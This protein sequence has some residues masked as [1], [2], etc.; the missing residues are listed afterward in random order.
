MREAI[1]RGALVRGN[2]LGNEIE[3]AKQFG[4]SRPT[5]RRAIQELVNQGL[6]VRK[7]GVGTQ[8]V[9]DE[10]TR[11]LQL[12]GLFDD[13]ARD[14]KGPETTVLAH[15]VGIPP[16]GVAA[17]LHIGSNEP[18]LHL[19]RLRIADGQPLAILENYLPARLNDISSNDLTSG[20]LYQAMWKAGVRMRVAN[21]RIGAREGTDEECRLLHEPAMS[22]MVTMER[23]T[24]EDSGGPVEWA[25]HV[26]RAS[27]Y[28]FT[29]TLVGK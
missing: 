8:I 29:I 23:L 12:T 19:R 17:K 1:R 14:N 24:H 21:Q 11:P 27:R 4:V 26:Y 25:Q 2:Q 16:P 9:D 22:P 7:R 20:G 3:L 13:L 5:T 6:V 18:V 28:E 15:E 10:I